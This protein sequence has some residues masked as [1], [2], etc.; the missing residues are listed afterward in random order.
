MADQFFRNTV[1][2]WMSGPD[3]FRSLAI[4]GDE[5]EGRR[6][7]IA[8]L[9][10]EDIEVLD[11]TAKYALGGN[12]VES[13]VPWELTSELLAHLEERG[14]ALNTRIPF[15]HRSVGGAAATSPA[16]REVL[17]LAGYLYGLHLRA[18]KGAPCVNVSF[19]ELTDLG[20]KM[21]RA[22]RR[23]TDLVYLC[24]LKSHFES[25]GLVAEIWPIFAE[26]RQQNQFLRTSRTTVLCEA[27]IS[28]RAV[29]DP[30]RARDG[31]LARN[32]LQG[33]GQDRRTWQGRTRSVGS[34]GR[35]HPVGVMNTAIGSQCVLQDVQ[36]RS[37]GPF[38]PVVREH[39]KVR[40]SCCVWSVLALMI[41]ISDFLLPFSAI[42]ETRTR[43]FRAP[44]S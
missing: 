11:F 18:P 43:E 25:S 27:V 22:T 8:R 40:G 13:S 35:P 28:R 41:R 20:R 4:E 2:Q 23:P 36:I 33:Q 38:R 6:Q 3:L 39:R 19:Y 21:L 31:H 17:F 14:L 24:R 42:M 16:E 30:D 1:N 32:R 5:D 29:A 10:I 15:V 7:L 12:L 37:F 9:S 34:P 44:N 26:E